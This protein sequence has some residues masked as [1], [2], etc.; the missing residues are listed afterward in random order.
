MFGIM[1]SVGLVPGAWNAFCQWWG[2]GYGGRQVPDQL[3]TLLHN[4]G[5]PPAVPRKS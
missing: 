5:E 4:V 2:Q 1:Q 3:L